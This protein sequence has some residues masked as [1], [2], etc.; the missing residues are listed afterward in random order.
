MIDGSTAIHPHNLDLLKLRGIS[1]TGHL[2]HAKQCAINALDTNYLLSA[3]EVMAIILHM[4]Q[5][6]D[7]DVPTPAVPAPHGPA[8]PIFAFVAGGRGSN[9]GRRHNPR[10]TR[11]GRGLPNRCSACGS[12]NHIMSSCTTSDDALLK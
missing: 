10:G 9:I 6:T 7:E 2:G 3:D 12:L 5:K 1:S 8:P 11:G 4:A